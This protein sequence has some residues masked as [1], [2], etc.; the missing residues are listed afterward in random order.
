MRFFDT[1]TL[2]RNML[3][4]A[5]YAQSAKSRMIGVVRGALLEHSFDGGKIASLRQRCRYRFH[6]VFFAGNGIE[7][8]SFHLH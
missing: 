4:E 6:K 8:R 3:R 7:V 5:V 2:K 1:N